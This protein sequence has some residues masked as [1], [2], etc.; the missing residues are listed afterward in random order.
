MIRKKVLIIGI[1]FLLA[2]IF[3]QFFLRD[4]KV[5]GKAFLSWNASTESD[6]S[7]YRIYYGTSKR[8]GDCPQGG[9]AKKIDVGNKTSYKIENLKPNSIYYFSVTSYDSSG[10]ES[11]FSEEIQKTIKI[12]IFDKLKSLF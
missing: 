4:L 11:C 5:S 8:T 6:V 7:G 10:K 12:S 2:I 3:W 9:Y 1:V